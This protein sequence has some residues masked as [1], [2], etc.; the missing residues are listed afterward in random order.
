M[1]GQYDG[2]S[3]KFYLNDYDFSFVLPIVLYS[4]I[5]ENSHQKKLTTIKKA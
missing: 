3:N 2:S 1:E 5:K 4:H